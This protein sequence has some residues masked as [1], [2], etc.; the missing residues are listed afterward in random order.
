MSFKRRPRR[1]RN[2]TRPVRVYLPRVLRNKVPMHD[3]LVLPGKRP[4]FVSVYY[5]SMTP[6]GRRT[7]P[8]RSMPESD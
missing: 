5:R 1:L 3:V 6:E 4:D 7:S 8:W 2:G